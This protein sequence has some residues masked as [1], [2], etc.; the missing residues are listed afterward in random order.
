MTARLQAKLQNLSQ[1]KKVPRVEC[2]EDPDQRR[3]SLAAVFPGTKLYGSEEESADPVTQE[4]VDMTEATQ[5]QRHKERSLRMP[6]RRRKPSARAI[7]IEGLQST[8][9]D[10]TVANLQ[11][12]SHNGHRQYVLAGAI[13]VSSLS[14]PDEHSGNSKLNRAVPR[15]ASVAPS[16]SKRKRGVGPSRTASNEGGKLAGLLPTPASSVVTSQGPSR[17]LYRSP[18]GLNSTSTQDQ[19]TSPNGGIDPSG[20][21]SQTKNIISQDRLDRD[22]DPRI[23]GVIQPRAASVVAVQDQCGHSIDI[24]SDPLTIKDNGTT[25]QSSTSRDTSDSPKRNLCGRFVSPCG[26]ST[27]PES[28]PRIPWQ[29]KGVHG[30][31]YVGGSDPTVVRWKRHA[32]DKRRNHTARAAAFRADALDIDFTLLGDSEA[33]KSH[34]DLV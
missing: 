15:V 1:A 14:H 5:S 16:S 30:M 4:A 13:E 22:R 33:D 27:A 19:S 34:E 11:H 24:A 9:T 3:L 32:S 7:N 20:P 18:D 26:Q 10:T 31:D 21:M 25:V 12:V 2:P 23:C 8:C 6:T 17:G 28:V 29:N